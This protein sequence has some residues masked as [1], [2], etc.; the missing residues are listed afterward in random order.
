MAHPLNRPRFDATAGRVVEGYAV[1]QPRVTPSL[2]VGREGSLF[3]RIFSSMSGIDPL[4]L[5]RLRRLPG[6]FRR[7]LLCRQG[8]LRRGCVRGGAERIACRTTRFS[9]TIFSK[10]L[11]PAPAWRPTSKSSRS[12]PPATTSPWRASTAGPAAIGNCC[13]GSSAAATPPAQRGSKGALP[14][15]GRWKML[16]NLR[17][18]LI[19]T[20]KLSGV[21]AGDGPCPQHDAALWTCFILATIVQCRP[22]FRFSRPSYRGAP[23]Q[24]PAKPSGCARRRSWPCFDAD[25]IDGDVPGPSGMVDVRRHRPDAVPPVREPPASARMGHGG[26]REPKSAASHLPVPIAGWPAASSIGVRVRVRR[27]VVRQRR[28]GRSQSLSAL[29]WVAAPAIARW[30]SLSPL[31]AGRHSGVRSRRPR[32]ATGR[33]PHLA[34]LRDLRH[35]S[36]PHAAAR[37]FPGR[38]ETGPR[39][40]DLAHQYW[41][42]SS[43]DGQCPRLRLGGNDRNRRA[44]G[45]HA[46]D[47]G[48]LERFRGHFYNWYDTERSASAGAAIRLH[49]GQRQSCRTSDRRRQCLPGMDRRPRCTCV[50]IRRHR[51]R[52]APGARGNRRHSR[53]PR[54]GIHNAA[55]A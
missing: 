17:R 41:P 10:E 55:G 34:L 27:L 1:L 3:Q 26:A 53:R 8:H 11:S 43:F 21:A 4:C 2:P 48:S 23:G 50:P 30:A 45:S 9:A 29:L 15:I 52:I 20:G 7:R 46:R 47:D 6:P 19:G 32:L 40:P 51:R 38:P 37:Q 35:G 54:T 44:P 12:F 42:L 14:L 31:V 24:R 25:R 28:L 33:T 39:T 49:R 5:G 36:G 13:L 18:T 22:C 16:D